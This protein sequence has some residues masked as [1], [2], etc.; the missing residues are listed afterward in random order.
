MAEHSLLYCDRQVAVVEVV[1]CCDQNLRA[2][3]GRTKTGLSPLGPKRLPAVRGSQT[4]FNQDVNIEVGSVH[5]CCLTLK[6]R[7]IEIHFNVILALLSY[8]SK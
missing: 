4:K 1:V 8:F 3:S 7:N 2:K 5:F 6:C